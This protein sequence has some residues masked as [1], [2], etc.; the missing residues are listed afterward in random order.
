M[1]WHNETA[2]V[3]RIKADGHG[4]EEV[5]VTPGKTTRE[6]VVITRGLTSGDRIIVPNSTQ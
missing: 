6:S 4:T 3:T 1:H 5:A 2:Y